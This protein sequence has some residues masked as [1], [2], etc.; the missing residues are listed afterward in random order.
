MFFELEFHKKECID[1]LEVQVDTERREVNKLYV[2][3][4]AILAHLSS[5]G[6]PMSAFSN[7]THDASSQVNLL[8]YAL[9]LLASFL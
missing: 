2:Q 4:N 7:A 9:L 1:E 3:Y 5:I 6:M 8:F